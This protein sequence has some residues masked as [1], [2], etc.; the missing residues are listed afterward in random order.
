MRHLHL[1]TVL[2]LAIAATACTQAPPTTV[3]TANLMDS[4]HNFA[5]EHILDMNAVDET[6][7]R[8]WAQYHKEIS[9][10]MGD[11]SDPRSQGA[12]QVMDEALAISTTKTS[13]GLDVQTQLELFAGNIPAWGPQYATTSRKVRDAYREILMQI[14]LA[15]DATDSLRAQVDEKLKVISSKGDALDDQEDALIDDWITR[16]DRN[17]KRKLPAITW[18]QYLET[19]THAIPY[20]VA[21]QEFDSEVAALKNLI[22]GIPT[23]NLYVEALDKLNAEVKAGKL[24]TSFTFS[25]NITDTLQQWT[26]TGPYTGKQPALRNPQSI[27]FNDTS[28][29]T[30]YNQTTWHTEGSG[31]SWFFR[32]RASATSSKESLVA[33][34][35]TYAMKI[36]FDAVTKV[37]ATPN[38]ISATL[39]DEYKNGP[40]ITG[41]LFDLKK[42][43]PFGEDGVLPMW[44][45]EFLV[46]L[47]PSITMTLD[48]NTYQYAKSSMSVQAG[49]S[50]GWGPFD[51][52]ASGGY[53]NT[54]VTTDYHDTNGTITIKDTSN[55]PKIIAVRNHIT[56]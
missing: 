32:A 44:V 27:A 42:A 30:D 11:V 26:A 29:S 28:A 52:A 14:K 36:D 39:L 37:V 8:L 13:D 31:G 46:V 40:W 12:I 9:R 56:P 53:S 43:Q 45:T 25:G 3:T 6:S 51:Y 2:T 4:P 15:P 23:A 24:T 5:H 33:K 54:H 21:R 17:E 19:N 1:A 41:S 20:T 34:N 22:A 55:L 50:Y 35:S 16:N 38:T 47:N 48:N 18:E 49:G 7:D 10:L